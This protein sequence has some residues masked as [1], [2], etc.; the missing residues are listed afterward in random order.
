MGLREER[1]LKRIA[2][3]AAA[4]AVV[5]SGA[6]LLPKLVFAGSGDAPINFVAVAGARPVIASLSWDPAPDT[7][8]DHYRVYIGT[9]EAGVYLT[10]IDVSDTSFNYTTGLGGMPYYFRVVAIDSLGNESEAAQSGAVTA[11]WAQTPHTNA[12]GATT[13]PMCHTPH[14][15]GR[16]LNRPEL[17]TTSSEPTALCVPCHDG[18]VS[19]AA[20]I[21]SGTANS[22]SLASGHM[23]PG[24]DSSSLVKNCSSCHLAHAKEESSPMLPA[25]R[26]N[27]ADVDADG[28]GWCISCH[29][30]KDSWYGA[31]YPSTD[32]PTRDASG[33]PTSGTWPQPDTYAGST[34]AHR[35]IVS[36]TQTTTAGT[37]I[38][39]AKGDCLYCHA[40]HQGPN[41]YDGLVAAF[42]PSTSSTLA[43]DQASGLYAQVCLACH[44]ATPPSGFT[45]ATVGFNIAQFVTTATPSA[46][47]RILTAGGTLPVGAPLPCY[48]CHNPHGSQ[49]GNISMISDERG[50]SLETTSAIGTRHFCFTC[51]S[52]ADNAT[53]WDST[54]KAYRAVGSATVEG[55]PRDERQLRLPELGAHDE[56]STT[57]C[58]VCH[59]DD[60]GT[61]GYNVHNPNLTG[62]YDAAMHTG[63]PTPQTF[64]I[65]G[66]TYPALPCTTC[67]SVELGVEHF[68]PTSAGNDQGCMLCHPSPRSTLVPDW[69][70]TTCVQG[71]CHTLSSAAPMH[72]NIDASH[73][74]SPADAACTSSGCHSTDLPSIHSLASTTTPTGTRVSCQVCHASGVTLSAVCTDCHGTA[75]PHAGLSDLHQSTATNGF[76]NLG[77]GTGWDMD[78]YVTTGFTASCSTCHDL[79]LM[80]LHSNNCQVC[81]SSTDPAVISA[82]SGGH[83]DCS[84]CHAS[85][86]AYVGAHEDQLYAYGNCSCHGSG[87]TVTEDNCRSCHTDTAAPTTSSDAQASYVGT[88]TIHFTAVD[89]LGGS[90]IKATYFIVDGGAQST[91]TSVTVSTWGQHKVEFWSVDNANNRET[92]HVASFLVLPPAGA[93]TVAPTTVSDAVASYNASATIHLTATDNAGGS[94]V[95]A[96]YYVLDSGAR[97]TG[98]VVTVTTAGSHTLEFWSVDNVG[99]V[100][101]PHKTVV[102]NIVAD[103]TAPTTTSDAVSNYFN[104]ATIHLVATDNAGG[105]GVNAT[106]YRVDSGSQR[107]GTTISVTTAGAH[108]IE[109]WSTDNAGNTETPHNIA[110]FTIADTIAPTTTS[111]ALSTYSGGATIHLTATDNLGGSGVSL[112]YY[113][114]DAGAQTAG[115]VVTVASAGPHTLEF[116]S[117]DNAGNVELSTT[118]AFTVTAPDTTPP[119]TTSDA[120]PTYSTSATIHL[121]ATDNPGG[122][123]VA[124]TY[125]RLDAGVQ[126]AGT[127][128]STSVGGAHTLEFWSVDKAGNTELHNTI[129]FM[130]TA[131][132]T[133]T[134]TFDMFNTAYNEDWLVA[135]TDY[136]YAYAF[137]YTVRDAG[138]NIIKTALADSSNPVIVLPAGGP[139]SVHMDLYTMVSGGTS[140]DWSGVTLPLGGNVTLTG[141]FYDAY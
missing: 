122:S 82:I 87:W 61:G 108:T 109:F 68:K 116:W 52:T 6:F 51:H 7:A 92:H 64:T 133:G 5:L 74:P 69:D 72:A 18:R 45:T 46:G 89:N 65:G 71:G 138:G 96:T 8:P 102:F 42:R 43:S 127:V 73:T 50:G 11:R 70:K 30:S 67:H 136:G 1:T 128:V 129:G 121:T 76:I 86:H 103:T 80:T 54:A 3:A 57:S 10:P 115:T 110:A 25:R 37:V 79:N 91:G 119:T 20:N 60:Y 100:E 58:D 135:L 98:A 75:D 141:S 24:A 78:H 126:T 88:A 118:R 4:I 139:Y 94:G 27:G 41:K 117:V 112:T 17:S 19:S 97:T 107:T 39:R 13:C 38:K 16:F 15:A 105:S 44:S 81:H 47:H 40:A 56:T 32:A 93:D 101:T 31:G 63:N 111:D 48:D 120:V 132:P 114:L 140:Y 62:G 28:S 34:N 21:T 124:A 77:L 33:Y 83:T 106:Y 130:V 35:L 22:F 12:I 66:V 84:A 14:Y 125:Y 85:Y 49:R 29:D 23:L 99:N 36:T 104:T 134:I 137:T 53:G 59:G 26:I 113:R 123:G 2:W 90:G 131:P 9:S 55:L 95:K